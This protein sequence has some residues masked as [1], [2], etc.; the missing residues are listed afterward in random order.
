MPTELQ[1]IV[2]KPCDT[3]DL[4]DDA[5]RAYL[6][7]TTQYQGNLIPINIPPHGHS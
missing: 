2:S 3:E 7:L 1:T 6:S 5:L 4:I